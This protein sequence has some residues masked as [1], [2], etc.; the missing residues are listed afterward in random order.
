MAITL[1]A[2]A[3]RL[4]ASQR[5]APPRPPRGCA[6]SMCAQRLSASQRSARGVRV[7]LRR[8]AQRAQRLSA[9]QRSAPSLLFDGLVAQSVL[10]AFRHHRGRH[11]TAPKAYPSAS[12]CAQRLSASQ[13]SALATMSPHSPDTLCAQRLS[14]SQRS[15]PDRHQDYDCRL[16]VLNA[17]RHHRGRHTQLLKPLAAYHGAQRLSAS[18]RSAP[19]G[20]G[21]CVLKLV[22]CSTPF[23][24][25]E[26]GT[27][28]RKEIHRT[29]IECSTPFG[30]TEVGTIDHH[31]ST[32]NLNVLNAFRH[33][34]GRHPK[35]W[36]RAALGD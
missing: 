32:L 11:T 19:A 12:M 20:I 16:E 26:V 2:G 30:I 29:V 5:S 34:R 22:R 1:M 4:S 35:K 18:Q 31:R 33:H 25:T 15:A 13:R 3:Q 7:V 9:S 23:G 36:T 8:G 14:A 6:M 10:N 28:L 17:F 21:T 24:I 27:S